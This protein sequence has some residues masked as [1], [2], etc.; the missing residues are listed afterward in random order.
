VAEAHWLA[1]DRRGLSGVAAKD[2]A[3]R[4]PKNNDKDGPS[5]VLI[6]G[7][8]IRFSLNFSLISFKFI[9][10]NKI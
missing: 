8:E 10:Y 6:D 4:A 1:C 9:I 5:R 2:M 7:Q 3:A